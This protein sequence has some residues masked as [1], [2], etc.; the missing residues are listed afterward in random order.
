M[1][2]LRG[3]GRTLLLAASVALAPGCLF[4][5]GQTGECGADDAAAG[6]SYPQCFA[7]HRQYAEPT[8]AGHSAADVVEA[9]GGT[10]L[11]TVDLPATGDAAAVAAQP[12]TIAIAYDAGAV[13]EDS[14]SHVLTIGVTVTVELGE[15]TVARAGTGR[16]TGDPTAA[17]LAVALPAGGDAIAGEVLIDMSIAADG[18][19]SGRIVLGSIGPLPFTAARQP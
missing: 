8:A 6:P 11:A 1:G 2:R 18:A 16:L 13:T 14:C 12:A 3:L 19:A 9:L 15:G 4:C 7:L 5:G 17:R 10:Y